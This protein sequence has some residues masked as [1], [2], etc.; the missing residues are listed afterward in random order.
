[1]I[2]EMPAVQVALL[3]DLHLPLLENTAPYAALQWAVD[4]IKE[5]RADFCFT[6]GDITAHGNPNG[7]A[8]FV[9]EMEGMTSCENSPFCAAVMGNAELRSPG[10]YPQL[11]LI[12][13]PLEPEAALPLN[14]SGWSACLL[15]SADGWLE[16][17][18]RQKLQQALSALPS[19]GKMLILLHH[20]PENLDEA[21]REWLRSAL[22]GFDRERL[23]L[24]HG[25]S[26]RLGQDSWEG[27]PL[28]SLQ[29]L[30]PD[31]AI[32]TP[33]CFTI[34]HLTPDGW[35]REEIFWP[36][37]RDG[38]ADILEHMGMSCFDVFGDLDE[39]AQKG[40][41]LLELR[42]S[43]LKAL[44]EKPLREKVAAWR[45]AGGRYLSLHFSELGWDS[46][47]LTGLENWENSLYLAA[48]L[49]PDAI[50]LHT[51]HASISHMKKDS[52]VWNRLLSLTAEG[53]E[54]LPRDC[55]VHIENM[56]MNPGDRDDGTRRFGCQPQ[57]VSDWM[58]ALQSRFSR[59]EQ[60][61]F[62]LDV[63]HARNNPP[64]N[65]VY[66]MSM[67]YSIMGKRMG[68]C[69]L[70]QVCPTEEGMKN[71]CVITD[72]YGPM[73]NFTSFV[74]SWKEGLLNRCP[75][76]LEVRSRQNAERS[77][78]AWTALWRSLP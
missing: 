55:A 49:R 44:P 13:S 37:D 31:K 43:H 33:P 17:A 1:M 34:L 77:R 7:A 19:D 66:T 72:C 59:P 61:S 70:H 5:R 26:H 22:S 18:Q 15:D 42:Q 64:Y 51:P 4:Q 65:S 52:P 29:A 6:L 74:W 8:R 71:H 50:T 46:D 56:H 3:C 21:S 27:F 20:A 69:H 73:I 68:G 75:I 23:L 32:G 78:D 40:V 30:D 67:W 45:S 60:I 48:L 14:R 62:L 9:R 2:K 47:C 16:Q 58:D 57:E 53:L 24:A 36:P 10:E 35:R 25:H 12:L 76:F 28:L 11:N 38:T 41:R 54:R 63:G 39:A